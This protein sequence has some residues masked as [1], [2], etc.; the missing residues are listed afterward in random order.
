MVLGNLF[1]R[2]GLPQEDGRLSERWGQ[3][4]SGIYNYSNASV[5]DGTIYTVTS[6]KTLYIK[7]ISVAGNNSNTGLALRDGSS[8]S[9]QKFNWVEFNGSIMT[10]FYF[11]VPIKFDTAIYLDDLSTGHSYNLTMQGW[12]E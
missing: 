3:D 9:T 10:H 4:G 11:D 7:A 6:N 2:G 1:D 12:E 8:G 5:S